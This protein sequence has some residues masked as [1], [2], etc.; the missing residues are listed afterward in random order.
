MD[1]LSGEQARD[2]ARARL[3]RQA[4]AFAFDERVEEIAAP[5]RR[6]RAA[7]YAR[8]TAMYLSHVAFGMSLGRVALAFGRDRSTVAH[9]CRVIEDRR[10]DDDFDDCLDRLE[11]F[12]R[13]APAEP[14]RPRWI[15]D[16]P[17]SAA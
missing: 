10:E 5:T 14:S 4:V 12:L 13:A 16:S 7:A 1:A 9:A 6:T 15:G 3:A 2:R 11:E 8:Q 17:R